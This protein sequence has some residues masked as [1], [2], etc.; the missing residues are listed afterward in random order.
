MLVLSRFAGAAQQLDAALLVNPHD[1]DAMAEA[2]VTALKMKLGERQER[3]QALWSA[4][5]PRSPLGWGRMFV[6]QLLR[7]AVRRGRFA[8]ERVYAEA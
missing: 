4:I 3:W 1:T 7:G 5:E 2:M 6:A 8:E